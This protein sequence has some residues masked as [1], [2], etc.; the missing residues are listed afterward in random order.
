MIWKACVFG[1]PL[2]PDSHFWHRSYTSQLI[3]QNLRPVI[4]LLHSVHWKRPC[5]TYRI[6]DMNL[7][8]TYNPVLPP[9][10]FQVLSV[11]PAVCFDRQ[12]LVA[13]RYLRRWDFL[14]LQ[15]RITNCSYSTGKEQQWTN[16]KTGHTHSD[17]FRH[18]HQCHTPSHRSLA[19]RRDM[20]SR[21]AQSNS[22]QCQSQGQ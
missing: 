21:V 12:S 6:Q 14:N 22:E 16:G 19:V 13:A 2:L 1:W 9:F 5:R 8:K 3:Q 20:H 15:N 18:A 7:S 4:G 10:A 11:L 17:D